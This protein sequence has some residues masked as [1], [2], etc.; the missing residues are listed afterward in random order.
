MLSA[1][2][3]FLLGDELDLDWLSRG[4]LP[5]EMVNHTIIVQSMAYPPLIIDPA[6]RIQP[7]IQTD[8]NG[9]TIDFDSRSLSLSL[10]SGRCSSLP[11]LRSNHQT[12]MSIEH[13][14]LSG[15]TI[16]IKAC[17]TLDSLLYPLAQWRSRSAKSHCTDSQSSIVVTV[18]SER[19][20]G[21]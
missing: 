15:S 8:L 18:I 17:H 7:W 12:G 1:L 20:R 3:E 13:S 21:S 16:Y 9:Q 10:S 11:V 6:H 19:E 4:R 2:I 5:S 14:F